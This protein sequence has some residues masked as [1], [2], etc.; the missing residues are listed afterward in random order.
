MLGRNAKRREET[1]A[2]LVPL[3]L[4]FARA[5]AEY[6][7]RGTPATLFVSYV[8]T[9]RCTRSCAYC[10]LAPPR[11][12]MT[13]DVFSRVFAQL[14]RHGLTRLCFTGGEP[15]L[16][17]DLGAMLRLCRRHDV[18]SF[19]V[20]N[21]DLL[22][23]DPACI[24]DADWVTIS[25]DGDRATHDALRGEGSYKAALEA[26]EI[27]RQSGKRLLTSTVV[28]RRNLHCVE[29]VLDLARKMGFATVWQ[30]IHQN[31]REAASN[32]DLRP[33][34]DQLVGLLNRLREVRRREP[35][36]VSFNERHFSFLQ[37]NYPTYA[38]D[39]CYAGQLLWGLSADGRAYPCYPLIGCGEGFDLT[40]RPVADLLAA[41]KPMHCAHGCFCSGHIDS[42]FL[43]DLDAH[44]WWETI[45]RVL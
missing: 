1:L 45:K 18:M 10:S 9:S 12:E 43:L 8:M 6:K 33:Q 21:G 11:G 39:A 40:R 13:L 3:A 25:L 14:V 24:A 35:R 41:A 17:P 22:A 36:L 15:L 31:N 44:V 42:R 2:D 28:T 27:A 37:G 34:L 4:R 38:T 29:H 16:H 26:L 19:L 20:T 7:L 23:N 5:V 32:V 30:P